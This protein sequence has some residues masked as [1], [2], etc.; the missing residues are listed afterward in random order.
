M[1]NE[2]VQRTGFA[3]NVDENADFAGEHDDTAVDDESEDGPEHAREP[4]QPD[5]HGGL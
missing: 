3:D 1:T 5:D 4:D 2:Q